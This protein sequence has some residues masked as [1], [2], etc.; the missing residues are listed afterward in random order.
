MEEKLTIT[1]LSDGEYKLVYTH[2]GIVMGTDYLPDPSPRDID[3]YVS[4]MLNVLGMSYVIV[5]YKE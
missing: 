5:E 3:D 1:K 4:A 2:D